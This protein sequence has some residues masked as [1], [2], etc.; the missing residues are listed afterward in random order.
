MSFMLQKSNIIVPFTYHFGHLS[1]VNFFS[2]MYIYMIQLDF[3]VQFIYKVF[4]F[5]QVYLHHN[6]KCYDFLHND[7]EQVATKLGDHGVGFKW[8]NFVPRSLIGAHDTFSEREQRD[9]DDSTLLF[10]IKKIIQAIKLICILSFLINLN[11]LFLFR[12]C[13]SV[14]YIWSSLV[15]YQAFYYSIKLRKSRDFSH[16]SFLFRVRSML[17]YLL[18]IG[19][20]CIR[21]ISWSSILLIY[22]TQY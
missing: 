6:C 1:V 8:C 10:W 13:F 19:C 4:Y 15:M 11:F 12:F 5:V 14:S 20:R 9:E 17:V 2:F 7:V 18:S 16:V 3:F 21:F 22:S